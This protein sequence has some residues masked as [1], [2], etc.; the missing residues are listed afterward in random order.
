MYMHIVW[1]CLQMHIIWSQSAKWHPVKVLGSS[2]LL[3]AETK[4]CGGYVTLA[5]FSCVQWTRGSYV[6]SLGSSLLFQQTIQ[7]S[8]ATQAISILCTNTHPLLTSF[9]VI[10]VLYS[11]TYCNTL[12]C[13]S[14]LSF[15]PYASLVFPRTNQQQRK[16]KTASSVWKK[17][18]QWNKGQRLPEN[19]Y[20][21]SAEWQAETLI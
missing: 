10:K 2:Q 6:L 12:S 9:P 19:W 17:E 3:N 4:V 1:C 16:I 18:L 21:M 5:S 13:S 7:T 15:L 20:A 14:A 8:K 11:S